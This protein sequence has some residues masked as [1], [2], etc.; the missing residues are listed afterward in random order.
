MGTGNFY[1]LDM[2]I[3]PT[4]WWWDWRGRVWGGRV[5]RYTVKRK[6]TTSPSWIR[7]SLPSIRSAP[8]SSAASTARGEALSPFP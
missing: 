2:R 6:C 7:Y 8:A 1:M 4:C 3:M 5:R